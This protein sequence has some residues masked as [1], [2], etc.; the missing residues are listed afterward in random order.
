VDDLPAVT[1][2]TILD[3]L[4]A[5]VASKKA[6]SAQQW[7]D[8]ALALNQL[9]ADDHKALIKAEYE[10]AKKRLAILDL[11]QKRNVAAADVELEVSDEYVAMR[12]QKLKVKRIEESILLAKKYAGL[13]G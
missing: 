11:Q 8:A 7:L 9:L 4:K 1:S 6:I 2:D 12:E 13:N 5:A 10:V 3:W